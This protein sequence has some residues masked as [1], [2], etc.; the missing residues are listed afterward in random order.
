MPLIDLHSLPAGQEFQSDLLIVGA[1]IA[2]LV[3]ADALRGSGRQ[4]DVLEAGGAS[5]E[6]ESQALY[7]GEMAASCC[8][9]LPMILRRG[10]MCLTAAGLSIPLSSGPT[11]CSASSCSA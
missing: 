7:A 2:G 8:R 6:P 9:S 3:L 1:G 10:P 4:V 5:L 11:C